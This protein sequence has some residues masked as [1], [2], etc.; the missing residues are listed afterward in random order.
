MKP[1]RPHL[2]FEPILNKA[3]SGR[4]LAVEAVALA[5]WFGAWFVLALA[6][7]DAFLGWPR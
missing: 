7:G 2:T 1:E 6:F 3:I 4:R 5:I